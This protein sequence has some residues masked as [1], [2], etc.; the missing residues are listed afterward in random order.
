MAAAQRSSVQPGRGARWVALRFPPFSLLLLFSACAPVQFGRPFQG[1]PRAIN[2][3]DHDV[4]QQFVD[5]N[6]RMVTYWGEDTEFIDGHEGYDFDLPEGTPVVAVADA[7]VHFAGLGDLYACPLLGR[8]TRD[9]FVRLEMYHRGELLRINYQHLSRIA[10]EEGQSVKRGQVVGYTGNTGCSM[11]PHLHLVVF[12]DGSDGKLQPVDPYGFQAGADPWVTRGG[13]S[14]EYLWAPGEAPALFREQTD[15]PNPHGTQAWVTITRLRWQ[16]V[17]DEHHP[18][19]EFIELTLDPAFAPERVDMQA[20][21]VTDNRGQVFQF[22]PGFALTHARP[23][24]RIYS[25]PG[26]NSD[27]ELHWGLPRGVWRN[28]PATDCAV[29]RLPN[30]N[31]YTFTYGRQPSCPP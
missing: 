25:G 6:R 13:P 30:G 24:V 1:Q 8:Q 22:P 19:N 12:R 31:L 26:T 5:T 16:G 11:A 10:V 29:L 17:D 28:R 9:L 15:K 23:T 7:R 21:S 27:T 18:N 20:Y 4:P 3:F 2:F 14:S